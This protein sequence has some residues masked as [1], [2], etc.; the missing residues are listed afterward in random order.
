[1]QCVADVGEPAAVKDAN[2]CGVTRL[3]ADEKSA[4]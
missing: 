1:M 2:I 3:S 4:P